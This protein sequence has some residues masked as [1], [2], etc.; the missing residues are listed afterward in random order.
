VNDI[1]ANVGVD[2]SDDGQSMSSINRPVD[3]EMI[4]QRPSH[5]ELDHTEQGVD[6][7]MDLID[8]S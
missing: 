7:L 1:D 6:S 8:E 2:A 4:T 5:A 3:L